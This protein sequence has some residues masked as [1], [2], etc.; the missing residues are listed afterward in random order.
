MHFCVDYQETCMSSNSG[1]AFKNPYEALL[2]SDD[3][4]V[5]GLGQ[6]HMIKDCQ[7][8]Q[9]EEIFNST[10]QQYLELESKDEKFS[11]AMFHFHG[12]GRTLPIGMENK[13]EPDTPV[14]LSLHWSASHNLCFYL[15]SRPPKEKVDSDPK[16]DIVWP[17]AAPIALSSVTPC[18]S[19]LTF[20]CEDGTITVWDKSLGLDN[21]EENMDVD[22]ES[23]VQQTPDRWD[24]PAGS[25]SGDE[26]EEMGEEM[27]PLQQN[28]SYQR[29]LGGSLPIREGK[30]P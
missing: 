9:L 28:L 4:T 11:H 24:K 27:G 21:S 6:N 19:H 20:V 22:I 8:E 26:K 10:F 25:R 13:S 17:C 23:T 1:C 12:P 30:S 3:G 18:S 14:A 2:K 29:P 16:P 5:V 7:W 15:L